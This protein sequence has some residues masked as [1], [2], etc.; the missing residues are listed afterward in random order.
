MNRLL[1]YIIK[2]AIVNGYKNYA[3]FS[4]AIIRKLYDNYIEY[5]PYY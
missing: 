3:L 1:S 2:K 4:K 5:K